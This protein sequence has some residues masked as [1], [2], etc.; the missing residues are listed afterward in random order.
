M[1]IDTK[2]RQEIKEFIKG[3]LNPDDSGI[4]ILEAV[5][6]R[7]QPQA[8]PERNSRVPF[9]ADI[10][11]NPLVEGLKA[12]G[13][14]PSSAFNL[15]KD[16]GTA[17]LNPIDT[18]KGIGG[19]AVGGVQKLIPG[20]QGQEEQFDMLTQALKERYGSLEALQRTA[21]EDP[22]GFGADVLGVITGGATATGRLPQVNRAIGRVG[23]AVTKPVSATG[24]GIGRTAKASTKFGTSQATGLAPETISTLFSK[25]DEVARA[26]A[27]GLDRVSLGRK[28]GEKI[29][30]R[31]KELRSTGR[32]YEPI[33]KLD[34]FVDV[35]PTFIDDFL[36][37]K[38]FNIK[39]GKIKATRLSPT[40][41]TAD[42]RALQNIYDNWAGIEKMTP[43]EFL[44]FRDD[45]TEL[46][47]FRLASAKTTKV[48][49]LGKELRKTF[50][51][52]YRD[53]ISGLK[54][55]DKEF[56]SEVKFLNQ[57]KKDFLDKDGTLKDAAY[58]RIANLDKPNR[59]KMM[60]RMQKIM[61]DIEEKIQ[62]VRALEDLERSKGIKVGTYTRGAA[63]GGGLI[64]GNIGIAIVTAL[65]TQ[66]EIAAQII[67]ALGIT[68]KQLKPLL[69]VAFKV[70]KDIN[71]ITAPESIIRA[72]VRQYMEDP[73][74]GLS[75]EDVS[76]GGSR[77]PRQ[78]SKV[79]STALPDDT[80]NFSR[81]AIPE[82]LRPLAEEFGDDAVRDAQRA[83]REGKTLEGFVEAQDTLFRGGKD[84]SKSDRQG[85]LFFSKDPQT[86][87]DIATERGG[88]VGE[89]VNLSQKP[90][91]AEDRF[92]LFK[93]LFGEDIAERVVLRQDYSDFPEINKLSR[94]AFDPSDL[95]ERIFIPELKKRG[96]DSVELRLGQTDKPEI[97]VLDPA[98]VKTKSQLTDLFNRVKGGEK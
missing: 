73:K 22:F 95:E 6:Q 68:S 84:L 26:K 35:S 4:N 9:Q 41:K 1:A 98:N 17:V 94:N 57:V 33:K 44:N 82:N 16:L 24:R 13:N 25:T 72:R 87:R 77:A 86:A 15:V 18:I 23:G 76:R 38:N 80:T 12:A 85:A 90:L 75:I 36:K 79:K 37:G 34:T 47:G 19:A 61:P 51:K 55:L 74:V 14:V 56:S 31:L 29:T 30:E 58:G 88:V 89:F 54:K 27:S 53:Q 63:I 45:L 11:G 28:V 8:Q 96:F 2:R 91:K 66:P 43:E 10:G 3:S 59:M 64:T 69:Q 97:I 52:K 5:K 20:E 60:A 40:R 78:Q 93:D 50:N 49:N 46:S 67:R 39:N 71:N 62:V 21:T 92:S 70:M 32:A 81:G 65:L 48:R 42:I 83:V 7:R